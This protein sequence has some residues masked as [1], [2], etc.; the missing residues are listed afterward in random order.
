MQTKKCSPEDK[1]CLKCRQTFSRPGRGRPKALRIGAI[2]QTNFVCKCRQ[3]VR[4]LQ[5]RFV[6]KCRQILQTNL[7]KALP[8]QM[9]TNFFKNADARAA[10]LGELQT[11]YADKPCLPSG[12]GRLH[13]GLSRN[14][15]CIFCLEIFCLFVYSPTVYSTASFRLV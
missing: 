13:F 7:F 11:N 3:K 8:P 4:V 9:Q 1:V 10:L 2:L 15:V 14:F 6:Y 12:W 5:T